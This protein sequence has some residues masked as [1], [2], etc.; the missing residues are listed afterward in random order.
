VKDAVVRVSATSM[1]VRIE[2]VGEDLTRLGGRALTSTLVSREVDPLCHPLGP[3]NK[4]VIAP[5]LLTGTRVAN[6]GRLSVGAKSPLTGGIKES[7]VGGTF[8]SGLARLGVRAIVVE[9]LPEASED[10]QILWVSPEGA[11]LESASDLAGLGTYDTL[12][13]L[14]GRS[15]AKISALVIGPGGE[16]LLP[17]A[18]IACTSSNGTPSRHA[19]RGGLGAVMGSK[20]IKAIVL[21]QVPGRIPLKDE[22]KVGEAI[23]AWRTMVRD[24]GVSQALREF[25]TPVSAEPISEVGGY[26]TRNFSHGSPIDI[27]KVSGATIR[28]TILERGG[29]TGHA[30]CSDCVIGCSNVWVDQ[31]GQ[32]VTSGLEYETICLNGMNCGIGDLDHLAR[33]DALCDDIGVDTIEV[34]GAMGVAMEAGVLPFGDTE[35]VIDILGQVRSGSPLGRLIAS[36]AAAVGAAYGVR[37]VP[38]VKGQAMAGYDPRAILGLGTVY[39]TSPMG[40]DHT[41]GFAPTA[42]VFG[43]PEPIDPL[44]PTVQADYA[45]SL[46]V[47][48]AMLD[49]LGLCTFVGFTLAANGATGYELLATLVSSRLERTCTPD[50]LAALGEDVLK[51]E[52]AFNR[53]AGLGTPYDRLPEFFMLEPVGP[54]D[55]VFTV[56]D[57][58]LLKVLSF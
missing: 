7:N 40:A 42:E 16:M 17:S 20:R 47:G 46:Q 14:T 3:G 57:S 33:V 41:A 36:G 11:R 2:P 21:E 18:S 6:A 32:E 10:W 39:A 12:K 27:G 56:P 29:K 22:G 30:A 54:H 37:R 4:L 5:G 51:T 52:V 45:R 58:E 55:V 35:G 25:G 13:R 23:E 31:Q 48:S 19:G 24:N 44:D 1:S 8:G 15:G 9:G 49:S 26:P 50:S 28:D 34:G 43:L 53:A 38:A